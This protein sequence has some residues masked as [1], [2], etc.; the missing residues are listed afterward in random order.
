MQSLFAWLET[1]P[2]LALYL[3]LAAAAAIENFFPPFPAD[4][5][6]AF[7]SFYAARVH[8]SVIAVFLSTL[9]GNLAG[10]M[11]VY[12]LGRRYGEPWLQRRFHVSE[13]K[14]HRLETAYKRWGLPGL[15]LSRFLPGIR[16]I[17]PPFAGAF[18]VPAGRAALAMGLAS[19]IWYGVVTWVAFRAGSSWSELQHRLAALGKTTA[20]VAAALVVIG[21]AVWLVL[22]ARRKA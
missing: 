5:V 19:A 18:K 2:P 15:F 14:E 13:Q 20:I 17:V 12:Y 1:L 21:I 4:T 6:V 22:R 10:A 9:A 16:A 7:G 8:G 3:A 11:A